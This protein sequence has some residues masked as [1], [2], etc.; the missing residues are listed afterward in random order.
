MQVSKRISSFQSSPIRRLVPYEKQARAK[1]L[2]VFHL[3][4]GQPDIK[5][6]I[7]AI[8]AIK[9]Y[10][11]SIIAY[12]VSE[13]EEPL[14]RAL[15]DYY[16]KY[17]VDV[18]ENEIMIT[19][20]GSE[21]LQ[22]MFITLCDEDDEVIVPE[23]FYTNVATF[24]NVAN[25]K[26]VPIKSK[27]EDNFALPPLAEFEEKIN[28]RTKAILICSPN[29]PTGHIYTKEELLILLEMC[30]KHNI[31]LIVD[32]VYRE[33]CYDGSKFTS[34]LSFPDYEDIAICVDSFS[35][36]F[37]M[38]GAR[39][40]AIVTKNKNIRDQVMKLLQARL[41]PPMV[42]QMAATAALSAPQSYT[43]EVVKEYQRRRDALVTELMEIPGVRLSSPKGAF[44]FVAELPVKD[45]E[46]FCIYLLQEFNYEGNT[47]M[48]APCEGFYVTEGS[49]KNQVRIAY[50]LNSEDLKK[51]ALCIK[52][53]LEEYTKLYG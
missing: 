7:E 50:V 6:P 16:K 47:V 46:H 39:I 42:E 11:E 52:I 18:N 10:D 14:R 37:S 26:L 22:F 4:I 32:E 49:G 30:K 44:Y 13:G 12:G 34:V 41:C 27:L 43:D 48:L 3:N 24:A 40:G 29:N 5:T 25:V 45:A 35:K 38:C 19:T 8:N 28:E 20:G 9:A 31:Y 1:G 2:N 51:A 33:L 53:A 15:V 17:D 21:A 36:R 23:P